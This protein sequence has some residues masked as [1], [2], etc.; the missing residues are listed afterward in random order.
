MDRVPGHRIALCRGEP[1]FHLGHRLV[2]AGIVVAVR[3]PGGARARR[4]WRAGKD[5]IDL[6]RVGSVMRRRASKRKRDFAWARL[7]DDELLKVRLK[8]LRLRLRGSWLQDCLREL[9]EELAARGL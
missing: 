2:L 6:V 7:P 9:N 8:D 5:A 3:N 1:V 4:R